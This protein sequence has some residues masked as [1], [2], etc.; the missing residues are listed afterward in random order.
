MVFA[1]LIGA[2]MLLAPFAMR[3][4][5][6]MAMGTSARAGQMADTGLSGTGLSG[7]GLSGTGHCS[8]QAGQQNHEDAPGDS[9]CKS[10][11]NGVVVPAAAPVLSGDSPAP[12]PTAAPNTGRHGVS[13]KLPTP[14]PRLS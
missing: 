1:M 13:A 6:A 12:L 5:A 11:C 8:E 7:T 9:I 14:P 10:M 2:A 4:G 3:S